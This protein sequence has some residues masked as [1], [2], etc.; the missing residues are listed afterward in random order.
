M[1]TVL[2]KIFMGGSNPSHF[3]INARIYSSEAQVSPCLFLVRALKP[4]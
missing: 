2:L 3:Q 4:S 1:M